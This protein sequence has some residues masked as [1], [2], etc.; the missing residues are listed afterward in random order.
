MA[1]ADQGSGLAR[2]AASLTIKNLTAMTTIF[3]MD[4]ANNQTVPISM[5]LP[6]PAACYNFEVSV[7]AGTNG[8]VSTVGIGTTNA[9]YNVTLSP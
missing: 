4:A 2:G 9:S 6:L 3:I 1:S 5:I 8:P 7:F